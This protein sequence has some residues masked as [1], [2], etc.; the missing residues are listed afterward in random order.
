M[1][2]CICIYTLSSFIFIHRGSTFRDVLLRIGEVC[3]LIPE[4]VPVMALTATTTY[5]LRLELAAI[6]GMKKPAV[7]VL[8]PNKPNLTYSVSQY[9]SI[10]ETFASILDQL[11]KERVQFPRTIIYCRIME[12]CQLI[13]FFFNLTYK[14]SLQNLQEHQC[15]LQNI[16]WLTCLPAVQI[17]MSKMKYLGYSLSQVV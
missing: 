6:I 3:S 10:E 9:I 1:Y 11:K 7:I 16:G 13:S 5:S 2:V 14:K 15:T 8:F 17:V 4:G 12:L